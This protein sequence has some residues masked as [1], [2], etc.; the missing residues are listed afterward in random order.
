MGI[1]G[2]PV[3]VDG[4][5]PRQY[6]LQ[7]NLE[8]RDKGVLKQ[9]ERMSLVI[10]KGFRVEG[11]SE[12]EAAPE[13]GD[14]S[15]LQKGELQEVCNDDLHRV[16]QVRMKPFATEVKRVKP[17]LVYFRPLAMS[18]VLR[19]NEPYSRHIFKAEVEYAYEIAEKAVV[20]VMGDSE[21]SVKVES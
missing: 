19:A 13:E 18:E 7:I 5:N 3:V 15:S 8:N 6:T 4:A 16:Y 11:V 20:R 17:Y 14:C 9:V 10:P 2:K 12:A 21:K 1:T